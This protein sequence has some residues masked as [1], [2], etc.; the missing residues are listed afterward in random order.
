MLPIE[1]CRGSMEDNISN[2]LEELGLGKYAALFVE[3]EFDLDTL[4][5]VTDE[6][7]EKMGVAL[8][9]RLKILAT[10]ETQSPEVYAGDPKKGQPAGLTSSRRNAERRQLTVMFCDLVG[11]TA[12]SGSL[13]PEE[14][15]AVILSFQN[16]VVGEATRFEGHVAR[17][18]GD[19]V[20]VY[21]GW[22]RAHEDDAE[23]AVQAALS[24]MHAL[25]GLQDPSGNTLAARIGIATGLVVVGDLIGEG[26]AQEEAVVGETPNLAARLQGVATPGQIV[27]SASTRGLIGELFDLSNLGEQ[28]L[29]G[30]ATP[31]NAFSVLGTRAIESRYEARAGETNSPMVGRKQELALLMERWRQAKSGEGQMVLLSGEAG[32]GKSRITRVAIDVIAQEPHF[33]INYQCSP[34]HGDSA[35]YPAIQQLSRAAKFTPNDN[36]NSKLDKLE[37]LLGQA[38]GDFRTTVS[39]F[40]QMLGIESEERYGN[41]NL[42]PQQQR[43]RTLS[44]L[45]DQLFSLASRRP[46]LFILEDAHWIDPTTLELIDLFLDRAASAPVFLLITARPTFDHGFGGHSIV[47]RLALNRLGRDQVVAIVNRLGGERLIPDALLDEIVVKTDGVPLFVEELTKAVLES[48]VTGIPASLHDSLMARLDRIPDVKEVAQIAAV[49]GRGFDYGLLEAVTER[50][51]AE[52][53]SCLKKLTAAEIIFSHGRSPEASYTFKHALVRDAAYESVL[54]TRRQELHG[55]IAE[56]LEAKFPAIADDQPELLAH[57]YTEAGQLLAASEKWLKAGDRSARRAANREAVALL[58]RG[59]GS[60]S[61]LE[62]GQARWRLELEL[63]MTLG[64]CLRTLKGWADEEAIEAVFKARRLSEQLNDS[65]YRGAIGLGEY[66]VHLVRGKLDEA[67]ACGRELLRL[68]EKEH[69]GVDQHIGHRALGATLVHIGRLEEA[70]HHL[71]AG[72]ALYDPK[73]EEETVHK[74]GYFSGVTLH[75]YLCHTLWHFGYPDKALKHLERSLSLTQ[76]LQHPPSQAFALFQASLHYQPLMRNDIEAHRRAIA[77][78]QA[79]SQEGRF[80]TWSAFVNSQQASLETETGD[81]TAALEIVQQNL[82]WWKASGGVLLVPYY[83]E[84]LARTQ[85]DL[86]RQDDA[87]HSINTAIEWSERFGEKWLIGELHHYKGELLTGCGSYENQVACFESALN[88]AREQA[89]RTLELRAATSL[90]RIWSEKGDRQKAL[91]LLAPLYGW[92]SEGFDTI[93]LKQSKALLDELT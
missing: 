86:G 75:S 88:I 15:R 8:G 71:E 20:L 28:N 5:Y 83:Y 10:I 49:I 67:V 1:Y 38:I 13:D 57:H 17:F 2:W 7:L 24:M 36:S 72:I 66:T 22:P 18:M 79:L 82:E 64:G 58:R 32:I 41:L 61:K 53:V 25:S 69:S 29:K 77:S 60:L 11:S 21:F 85:K 74:I 84:M 27:I 65:P 34:Y 89:S 48:G 14:L 35:L 59:L 30:I 76:E 78:F 43:N 81:A 23:R 6:A 42:S 12:L 63:L 87:A 70:H 46:V 26:A 44:A 37:A 16:A 55:K 52:L 9:A 4:P 45:T 47:T 73:L 40:A 62:E 54:K 91:D 50:P 39:L 3:N 90:A 92:F 51:E 68:G 56:V 93:D 80:D 19:G 31:T 33:R